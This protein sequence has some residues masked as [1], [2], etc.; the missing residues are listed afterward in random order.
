MGS[1]IKS[2]LDRINEIVATTNTT[3][4]IVH[5]FAGDSLLLIGSFDLCYYHELE[6]RF[7]DVSYIGLTVYALNSPRLTVASEK[8]RKA[9][10]HLELDDDDVLFRV[11]VD[12]SLKGGHVYYVA[13]KRVSISEDIV[14]H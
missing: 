1:D 14:Y 4:F 11:H 3:D 10:A 7:H 9:H 2:I 5:S 8:E 6:I 13:A 12:P